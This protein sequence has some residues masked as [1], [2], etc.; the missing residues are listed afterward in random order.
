MVRPKAHLSLDSFSGRRVI[1]VSRGR[2][3]VDS[4]D[5]IPNELETILT[6]SC[7]L[8][9]KTLKV[10][11]ARL[12]LF[13]VS[14]QEE[15][16]AAEYPDWKTKDL[17]VSWQH[18]PVE[19][20][21][22]NLEVA[23]RSDDLVSDSLFD[24]ANT[25]VPRGIHSVF[26]FPIISGTRVL[27]SLALDLGETQLL[28][29]EEMSLARELA[30]QAALAINSERSLN[31]AKNVGAMILGDFKET[32]ESVVTNTQQGIGCDAVTVFVY[33]EITNRFDEHT[34]AAGVWNIAQATMCGAAPRDS[35]VYKMLSLDHPYSVDEI[36]KNDL[37][38]NTRFSKEEK[39]RSL[40][41]IPLKVNKHRVGVM[42][43][44]YRSP[45]KFTSDEL[46]NIESLFANPAAIA[47]RN[48]LIHEERKEQL[49]AF[50]K[51]SEEITKLSL[52]KRVEVLDAIV[53]Q[54][55][56][57]F[58]QAR[59]ATIQVYDKHRNELICESAAPKEQFDR[60]KLRGKKKVL[61]RTLHRV[62]IGG[63]A[64]L[65]KQA[66][67][68][69][70]VR[71][72]ADYVNFCNTTRS[73][74][75]V[76]F[77]SRSNN[78]V[79]SMGD[80]LGVLSIE[81]DHLQAFDGDDKRLLNAFAGLAAIT[82]QNSER[83]ENLEAQKTLARTGMITS[84]WGHN[85]TGRANDIRDT[86]TIA[87]E[88]I[89]AEKDNV[90]LRELIEEKLSTIDNV[91]SEILEKPLSTPLSDEDGVADVSVNDFI[92]ERVNQLWK[93]EPYSRVRLILE[94]TSEPTLVRSNR[95]WLKRA[96]DV[97]LDNAVQAMNKS[98]TRK[99]TILTTSVKHP[100]NGP[101]IEIRL[102]DTG[103]GIPHEIRPRLFYR[104]IEKANGNKGWG[105]GL[106]MAQ[107]IVQTYGGLIRVE[108]TSV[109]GTTMVVWLPGCG[110]FAE[111]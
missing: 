106:L 80:V 60:D 51:A 108:S 27:G 30:I 97:L 99:L 87:R 61:D 91:A 40:A 3:N 48:G 11:H 76:P 44:N 105:V 82:I 38:K 15:R 36:G 31:A 101:G 90:A 56:K 21:I 59:L 89:I 20:Q 66:E 71:Y 4:R 73:Q 62:G 70:D 16:V 102:Q 104:R 14:K 110:E 28:G 98:M 74:L 77:F 95:F 54:A 103:A 67:G 7:R 34:S 19:V 81:S 37:F 88:S 25:L 68:S 84:V 83:F 52:G 17:V 109:K 50:H 65:N 86:I 42:F 92:S 18:A 8:A 93:Y 47:I 69:G 100:A 13:D 55:V 79:R 57:C 33:N 22:R 9:V 53:E 32:L 72:D 23:F 85:V 94:L 64:V 49:E 41:A 58:P 26:S 24:F 75:A 29:N 46:G 96:L 5:P 39:I 63:R 78:D 1:T 2:L 6:A 35:V 12:L 10:S 43:V 107:A 45:H 111:H